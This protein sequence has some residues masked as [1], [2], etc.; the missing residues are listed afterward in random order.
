MI[1][2]SSYFEPEN[3]EE[4]ILIVKKANE[5]NQKIRVIGG[6]TYNFTA[7][8][9][10]SVSSRSIRK[11]GFAAINSNLKAFYGSNLSVNLIY[12]IAV[13]KCVVRY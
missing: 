4:V 10:F 3:I 5:L 13:P 7:G 8:L 11:F 12:T 9:A 2:K 6:G 1:Y